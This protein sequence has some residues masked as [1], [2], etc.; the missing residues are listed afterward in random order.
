MQNETESINVV[1]KNN[2]FETIHSSIHAEFVE[3]RMKNS[4]GSVKRF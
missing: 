3:W 1:L 4:I 2:L